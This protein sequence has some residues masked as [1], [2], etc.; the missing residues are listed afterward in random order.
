MDRKKKIIF[1]YFDKYCYG[2]LILDEKDLDWIKPDVKNEPFG[3]QTDNHY[4]FFNGELLE[5]IEGIFSVSR[6]EF[7]EYLGEWF[8]NKYNLPVSSVL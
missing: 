2:K 7:K 1:K 6:T 3:Y 4:L 5:A 8:K